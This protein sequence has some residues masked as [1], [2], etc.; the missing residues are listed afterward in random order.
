MYQGRGISLQSVNIETSEFGSQFQPHDQPRRACAQ[1]PVNQ[2]A[3]N[4]VNFL[5]RT[6]PSVLTVNAP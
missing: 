5:A 1:N 4:R 6:G 3:S 2:E